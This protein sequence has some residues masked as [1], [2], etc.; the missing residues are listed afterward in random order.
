MGDGE[1][2]ETMEGDAYGAAHNETISAGQVDL[3]DAV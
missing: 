2:A 1:W 3:C